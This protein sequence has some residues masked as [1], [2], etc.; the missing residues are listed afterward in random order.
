M[1]N[2]EFLA[3]ATNRSSLGFV[4]SDVLQRERSTA[5]SYKIQE[6]GVMLGRDAQGKCGV[7]ILKLGCRFPDETV[8]YTALRILHGK[9]RFGDTS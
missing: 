7:E 2:P 6:H 3:H 1:P 5:T 9:W 4:A 8:W